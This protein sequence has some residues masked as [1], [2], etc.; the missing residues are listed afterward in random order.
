MKPYEIID[1]TADLGI[2]VYG[3]DLNSLFLNAARAM[4]EIMLEP[5]KK[6]PLFQKTEHKKFLVNKKGSGLEDIFIAWMSELLYLFSAE[7][8]IMDK[9]DIQKLD[10]N[11]I[12]AEVSG[13]IFDP[14]YYRIK[15]EIKAVTYHELEVRQTA[16]GYQAQVIFDI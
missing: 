5:I 9:A 12:Q 7:G 8:L 15:T 2:K 14:E 13:S 1:H 11:C 10:T 4:F 3:K 6:R 16:Q